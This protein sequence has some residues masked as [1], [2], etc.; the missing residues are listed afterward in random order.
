MEFAA[1]A[2]SSF[3]HGQDCYDICIGV[4]PS[5]GFIIVAVLSLCR[6]S[7]S[8]TWTTRTEVVDMLFINRV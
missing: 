1:V 2:K 6:K 8:R 4:K 5:A 3:I 7:K